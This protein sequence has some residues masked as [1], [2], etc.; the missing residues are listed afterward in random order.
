MPYEEIRNVY[1][2][3]YNTIY[4]CIIIIMYFKQTGENW[5][6]Y[7]KHITIFYQSESFKYNIV[8]YQSFKKLLLPG[9]PHFQDTQ[10]NS[11]Y[12]EF[13]LNQV[14]TGQFQDFMISQDSFLI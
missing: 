12:F 11:E 10:D 9:L 4:L 2:S 1:N 14:D 5:N 13:F 3:A 7:T 8:T 6:I